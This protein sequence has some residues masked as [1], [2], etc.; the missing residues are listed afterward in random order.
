MTFEQQLKA[1]AKKTGQ[2]TQDVFRQVAFELS[3]DVIN[4]TPVD[5]GGAKGSWTPSINTVSNSSGQKGDLTGSKAIGSVRN[6]V[7]NLKNG[8]TFFLI[9]N[10]EY[11]GVLEYGGYTSQGEKTTSDGYSTQAPNGMVRIAAD[12]FQKQLDEAVKDVT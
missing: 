2:K 9:S 11:I 6:K 1:F 3:V 12:N 4:R 7:K 8:N 10:L 5:M